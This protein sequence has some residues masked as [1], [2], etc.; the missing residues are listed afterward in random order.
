MPRMAFEVNS[1]PLS[2]TVI[3]GLPRAPLLL[4]GDPRDLRRGDALEGKS[5]RS[6]LGQQ[7]LKALGNCEPRVTQR[8]VVVLQQPF[9]Q[10]ARPRHQL[11]PRAHLVDRRKLE[12]L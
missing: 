5:N 1:V 2:E 9:G 8:Q 6:S 4:A 11:R 10:L 7:T 3:P 12:R